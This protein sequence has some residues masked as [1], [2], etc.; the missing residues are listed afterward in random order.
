[1]A[2][3]R[4]DGKNFKKYFGISVLECTGHISILERK[5][6]A[7][8]SWPDEDGEEPFVLSDDI[9]FKPRDISITCLMKGST[10]TNFLYR[11][12]A[13]RKVLESPGLHTLYI[14]ITGKTHSVYCMDGSAPMMLTKWNTSFQSGTT[15][16]RFI[17]KL[18]EPVPER[19]T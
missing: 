4:L 13:L 14:G 8:H 7:G 1:M 19:A 9:K 15:I 2:E 18:R 10:T 5:G 16:G 3:Y 11:F 6:D 17:L 12:N